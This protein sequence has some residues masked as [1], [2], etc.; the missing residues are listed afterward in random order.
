M[1]SGICANSDRL[2]SLKWAS[3]KQACGDAVTTPLTA[4]SDSI[5]KILAGG[6]WMSTGT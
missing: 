6:W 2:I 5:V 3:A 4:A 1:A